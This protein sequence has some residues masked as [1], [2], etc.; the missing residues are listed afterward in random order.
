M[1]VLYKKRKI[2]INIKYLFHR[3]FCRI[4]LHQDSLSKY[5]QFFLKDKKSKY[6][7]DSTSPLILNR[8]KRKQVPE[9]F[10]HKNGYLWYLSE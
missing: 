2:F 4:Y 9:K 5:F 7:D 1:Y 10:Y 3:W 6:L 8:S